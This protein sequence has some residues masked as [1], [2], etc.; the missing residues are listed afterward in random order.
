M[1]LAGID[2]SHSRAKE[3]AEKLVALR[4]W[5]AGHGHPAVVLAGPGPLAW[6][7]A[8]LTDP[9]ARDAS[10]GLVWVIVT[11]TRASIVTT[12]I[13]D[14]RLRAEE[15][16]ETLGFELNAAPWHEPNGLV[17]LAE[18]IAGASGLEIASDGHPAFGVDADTE[19]TALRITLTGSEVA[20][21]R[22]LGRDAAAA[23]ENALRVWRAGE[24]DRALQ[25]RVAASLESAGIFASCLIVGGDERLERYR[26]PVAVGA[27]IERVAMVVVVGQRDGLHV[28]LTRFASAGPPDAAIVRL[29]EHVRAVE[30]RILDA[31]RPGTTYGAVTQA[32]AAGYGAAGEAEAWRDHYQGGPLGYRQRE[33]EIAPGQV[34]S[35]WWHRSAA[36]G[37]AVAYNPS[38]RGGGKIED[39]FLVADDGPE[40]L[41]VSGDWPTIASTPIGGRIIPRP[42]ILQCV[43]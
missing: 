16:I 3:V 36:R 30:A 8:G 42:D 10:F 5:L 27:P 18:S 39:T 1:R 21:I 14:P 9:I 22:S 15:S 29:H 23:V 13:E 7:T 28:A 38:L 4:A 34:D 26:H 19:L 41:T 31:L 35:V 11:P 20:R 25:A 2:A 12:N 32:L 33:F 6:I 24:R 17:R 37:D 43:R 40:L